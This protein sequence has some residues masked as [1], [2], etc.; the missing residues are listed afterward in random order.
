MT[1]QY[2]GTFYYGWVIAIAAG[3]ILLIGNGMTL[4]GLN[5]FDKPLLAALNESAG[6]GVTLAGLKTRDAITLIFGGLMSP[7]A[8][9]AADRFGVRPLMVVG[10]LF[11]AA[12]FFL[13]ST[14]DSLSQIYWIHLMFAAGLA[15]CG[16]VVV[17]ILI[18]RWFIKDRGLAMGI[19]IAGTS[20][21]NGT[22]P[23]VNAALIGEFGWR[24][25]FAWTSL[26]PLLLLP[27]IFFVIRERPTD[28]GPQKPAA[29]SVLATGGMSLS[30]ALRTRNFWL[31]AFI[32]MFSFF[33]IIGT[34]AH[35]NLYMLS[36]GFSQMDAG[37]SYTV[38]FYVG[39]C[40]K[41]LNGL[42]ADRLGKKR[43]FVATL[44]VMAAGTLVLALPQSGSIW[45]GL[46]LFGFG[47]GGLY[48]LLQL[49]A[50]DYFGPRHLGKILGVITVLDTLG[51]GLGPPIL[52][53][54][55]DKTG[56]YDAAFLPVIVLVGFAFILSTLF[57]TGRDAGTK[58]PA[59]T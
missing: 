25:T 40:G 54:I 24:A 50:A 19:A 32:A 28:L 2:G 39:L 21:G 13:Y 38:L 48:T 27:V 10:A 22:M 53:A 45:A 14:V 55:L 35:L 20:L 31:L 8:G 5:V 12:G 51:G 18:S 42:L 29:G 44:A 41:L 4:G 56:S 3:F 33:S 47:W 36:R 1:K 15:S 58:V 17:V 46:V 30:E 37:F 26:L 34:Q 7:I 49:L 59:A 6:G 9:A 23:P 16:L 52:G 43:I 11:L 57:R